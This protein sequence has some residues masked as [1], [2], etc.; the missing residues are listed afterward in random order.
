MNCKTAQDLMSAYLDRE[1]VG[2]ELADMRAHLGSCQACTEEYEAMSSL[3]HLLGGL[4]V[5]E[6]TPDFEQRLVASVIRSRPDELRT[7]E[8]LPVRRYNLFAFAGIAACSM[9]LTMS[10]LSASGR[11]DPVAAPV[12]D[13]NIAFE[14]QR[15]QIYATG[16]DPMS[17]APV[18]SASDYGDQP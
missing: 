3:K 17:G 1:L 4:Q 7:P 12:K 13:K 14:V 11:P 2:R 9:A 6:P 16:S 18:I 5:P 15:D 8:R 10:F